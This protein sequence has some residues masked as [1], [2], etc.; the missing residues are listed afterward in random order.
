MVGPWTGGKTWG[1]W[2]TA[3]V[4]P[5]LTPPLE[6]ELIPI[7]MKKNCGP[8]DTLAADPGLLLD[9]WNPET[10]NWGVPP[11]VG[12]NCEAYNPGPAY[13][14]RRSSSIH[15]SR[16]GRRA[17]REI[18]GRV[19]VDP[20]VGVRAMASD[21]RGFRPCHRLSR[22]IPPAGSWRSLHKSIPWKLSCQV[23]AR[24]NLEGAP[25]CA[26]PILHGKT[27]G[28][29][30]TLTN[31]PPIGS[32]CQPSIVDRDHPCNH[33]VTAPE[34]D[35]GIGVG[36]APPTDLPAEPLTSRQAGTQGGEIRESRS[37]VARPLEA[38]M[39]DRLPAPVG[40]QSSTIGLRVTQLRR[41]ASRSDFSRTRSCSSL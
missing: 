34:K 4:P 31:S 8:G 15:S 11:E 37:G 19:L 13:R 23:Y 32:F 2:K 26:C 5:A 33:G 16:S 41:Q 9:C 20:A 40:R 6:S 18:I 17:S 28:V 3:D 24:S 39:T 7:V 14:S 10:T 35:E 12:M 29:R 1:G 30:R 36:W 27:R 21:L 25:Q 22:A 38:A